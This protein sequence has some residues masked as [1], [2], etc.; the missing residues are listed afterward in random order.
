MPVERQQGLLINRSRECCAT[1]RVVMTHTHIIEKQKKIECYT[2]I[3]LH[4]VQLVRTQLTAQQYTE[5]NTV[6]THF[7]MMFF[8]MM[9]FICFLIWDFKTVYI[10]HKKWTRMIVIDYE[11]YF[12]IYCHC[13]SR[14]TCYT[15]IFGA[16]TW[17]TLLVASDT[18][19]GVGARV[20]EALQRAWARIRGSGHIDSYSHIGH[21]DSGLIRRVDC[22]SDRKFGWTGTEPD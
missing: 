12:C 9:I 18:N 8:T 3:P 22:N 7:T 19:S 4:Y 13:N 2:E 16:V 6:R 11:Q 15:V 10:D 14:S 17:L 5:Y 1:H 21:I 20:R